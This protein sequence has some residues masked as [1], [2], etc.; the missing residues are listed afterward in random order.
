[1]SRKR[2]R[3]FDRFNTRP[4]A[5]PRPIVLSE[6]ADQKLD[7][8][9]V[10]KMVLIHD[11]VEIDAGNTFIYDQNKDHDNTEEE[12]KATVRIFGMLPKKQTSEFIQ[13]WTEFEDG[14][15]NEAQFAKSLDRLEPLLQNALARAFRLCPPRP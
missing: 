15:S 4:F 7:L 5:K 6:Y 11:I 2:T 3:C 13:L 8:L 9:K 1:M 10:I 14:I 12:L